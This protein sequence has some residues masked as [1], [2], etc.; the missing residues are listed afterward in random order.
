[1]VRTVEKR[2][3][4]TMAVRPDISLSMACC[5]SASDSESRLE[6]ASSRIRMGIGEE[7]TGERNSLALAARELHAAFAH[8]GLITAR[9]TLDE[10]MSIRQSRGAF[11]LRLRGVGPRI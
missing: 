2:C 6:V 8:Q 1:M 5:M 9:Q 7:S 3:A 4:I 10:L 11:D